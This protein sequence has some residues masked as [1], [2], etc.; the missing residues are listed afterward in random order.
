MPTLPEPGNAWGIGMRV[1]ILG[2]N[3]APQYND[4]FG[5][6]EKADENSGRWEIR[7]DHDNSLK[8][9]KNKNLEAVA[10]APSAGQTWPGQVEEVNEK[11]E[12]NASSGKWHPL[13]LPEPGDPAGISLRVMIFGLNSAPQY[14]NTLG[15]IEKSDWNSGRWEIRM[16]FDGSLK[17]L[18]NKNLQYPVPDDKTTSG[19]DW[20]TSGEEQWQTQTR[21]Q[22][23]D[24]DKSKW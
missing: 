10:A 13:Q 23:N 18:K 22:S 2:L 9:L 8:K 7:M 19:V 15:T 1:R 20:K 17:K 21:D 14:N 5:T 12:A 16:D 3:S 24:A 4:T 6:I 11:T